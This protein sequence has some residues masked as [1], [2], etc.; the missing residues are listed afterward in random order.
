M[1]VEGD[2]EEEEEE[3]MKKGNKWKCGHALGLNAPLMGQMIEWN[4]AA[5]G[6]EIEMLFLGTKANVCVS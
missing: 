4:D 3:N 5:S 1:F 2:E 6:D